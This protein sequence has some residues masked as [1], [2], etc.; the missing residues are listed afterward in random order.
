MLKRFSVQTDS[1]LRKDETCPHSFHHSKKYSF[2][3]EC[4]FQKTHTGVITQ[5]NIQEFSNTKIFL[6]DWLANELCRAK[7]AQLICVNFSWFKQ[8][9]QHLMFEVLTGQ[10]CEINWKR[11]WN[12]RRAYLHILKLEWLFDI[13]C[14]ISFSHFVRLHSDNVARLHTFGS[15]KDNIANINTKFLM[16]GT[17]GSHPLP[18]RMFF[19]TLCKRPL[20]PPPRFFHDHVVDFST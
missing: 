13:K 15:S 10:S 5:R 3:Q 9:F 12:V 19:Y 2:L 6:N 8:V 1:I 11:H 16:Y 7:I 20:T 4:S 14:V 17:K 18:N